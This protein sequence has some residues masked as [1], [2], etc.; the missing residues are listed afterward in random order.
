MTTSEAIVKTI[1]SN[2]ACKINELRVRPYVLG[3]DEDKYEYLIIGQTLEEVTDTLQ[4]FDLDDREIRLR[5]V[6]HTE[7]HKGEMLIQTELINMSVFK[8]V[9]AKVDKS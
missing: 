4:N 5:L 9:F 7:L 2:I 1:H 8:L 3:I 6:E